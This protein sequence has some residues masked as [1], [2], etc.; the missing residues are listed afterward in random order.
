MTT[1]YDYRTVGSGI[2]ALDNLLQGIR[3]GDN[4]VWQV[5]N[6][7]DYAFFAESFVAQ[8]IKHGFKCVYVR[9][10]AHKAVLKP[11]PGLVIINVTRLQGLTFS[12]LRYTV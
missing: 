1:N 5:D 11:R 2:T 9:F 3:L 8:S 7:K 4:I 12:A 10:A 6:L